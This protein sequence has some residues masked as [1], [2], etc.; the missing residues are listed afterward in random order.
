MDAAVGKKEA[1][2]YW[3]R[4]NF[5]GLSAIADEAMQLSHLEGFASYC[6]LRSNGLRKQAFDALRTFLNAVKPLPFDGRKAI[7]SWLLETRLR[8]PD[9]HQLL[10]QP[11][12][13]ELIQPTLV[14]WEKLLPND[15]AAFRWRGYLDRDADALQRAIAIDEN[16]VIAR[17]L[18]I[19]HL[20]GNVDFATHHL[21]ESV[22]LA[23]EADVNGDL[24]DIARHV[25][26]LPP[27]ARREAFRTDYLDQRQL[28]DDWLEYKTAP[29]GSFP[30]WCQRRKRDRQWPT[31]V[32]Y[33]SGKPE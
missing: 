11:L 31:I 33:E 30:E 1:M 4:D 10:P 29:Q 25:M 16:D 17:E 15:S 2:H 7:S 32:Y 26:L 18:L 20:M 3:N 5:E 6:R 28:V 24:N 8:S 13:A 21:V 23:S 22:L 27:G 12:V 14:E 19:A 9:V